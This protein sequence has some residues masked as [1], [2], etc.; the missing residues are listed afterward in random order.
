MPGLRRLVC[1]VLV[2]GLLSLGGAQV[3]AT[4]QFD[5]DPA[6]NNGY[7]VHGTRPVKQE[8]TAQATLE[9]LQTTVAEQATM[10]A[11]LN[12]TESSDGAG[13]PEA[14]ATS[15][16]QVT[17]EPVDLGYGVF[18]YSYL[19][20]DTEYGSYLAVDLVNSSGSALLTP[21]LTATY[22]DANGSI[23]GEDHLFTSLDWVNIDSHIPYSTSNLL[24]DVYRVAD[25]NRIAFSIIP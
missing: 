9:A 20:A 2:V 19:L 14:T 18:L 16:P 21:L 17:F 25:I 3:F 8:D 13:V 7:D 23:L 22:F 15:V 12:A 11:G 5:P 1:I 24:D 4:P 6:A 10:I